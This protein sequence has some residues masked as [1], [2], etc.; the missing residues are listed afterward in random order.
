MI[1]GLPDHSLISEKIKSFTSAFDAPGVSARRVSPVATPHREQSLV[2]VS[3]ISILTYDRDLH[4]MVVSPNYSGCYGTVNWHELV[5]P[6]LRALR[7]NKIKL[8]SLSLP[9]RDFLGD[10]SHGSRKTGML[11]LPS[12]LEGAKAH[13]ASKTSTILLPLFRHLKSLE[14]IIDFKHPGNDMRR[15]RD[16]MQEDRLCK[17]LQQ[18]KNIESLTLGAPTYLLCDPS[19][20]DLSKLLLYKE[21]DYAPDDDNDEDDDALGGPPGD[22]Q[23]ML[24]AIFGPLMG[25]AQTVNAGGPTAPPGPGTST[26]QGPASTSTAAGG[27][28]TAGPGAPSAFTLGQIFG[29]TVDQTGNLLSFD[30]GA[31]AP[32]GFK[33]KTATPKTPLEPNPWPKL[34]YLALYNLPSS[35]NE[36]SRLVTT[37]KNSLKVLKMRN[38]HY[39]DHAGA[40]GQHD[41]FSLTGNGLLGSNQ[42]VNNDDE[43][44]GDSDDDDDL[45]SLVGM[46]DSSK[47]PT[48]A[49]E[50]N[51]QHTTTSATA[52]GQQGTQG[53]SLPHASTTPLPGSFPTSTFPLFGG[54]LPQPPAASQSS[55][56]NDSVGSKKSDIADQWLATI[57]L[58]SDELR[59]D[60]CALQLHEA[61]QAKLRVKL[62]KEVKDLW[63]IDPF[64]DMIDKYLLEGSGMGLPLFLSNEAQQIKSEAH[65]RRI[66]DMAMTV[67]PDSKLAGLEEEESW[68]D[69]GSDEDLD[70]DASEDE[71]PPSFPYVHICSQW[72][73]CP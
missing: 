44:A 46:E 43:D 37:V 17:A 30:L 6:A 29:S 70:D 22:V 32:P 20:W 56:N 69:V 9:G 61:E 3:I 58:L 55:E 2:V 71:R 63:M 25:T 64:G 65:A 16:V 36:V 15:P 27:N 66:R 62:T 42:E 12:L 39:E 4:V 73:A 47:P 34:K 10:R 38:I 24:S 67:M 19:V 26:S 57:E 28:S 21:E 14:L 11:P 52:T 48:S 23:D 33:G 54:P 13:F 18:M 31:G 8:D 1:S 59:L 45:P 41:H 68:D 40:L 60:E 49:P 7:E 5:N 53:Q 51:S 35:P 72:Q 50:K